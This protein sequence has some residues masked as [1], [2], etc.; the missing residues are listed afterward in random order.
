MA[1]SGL[2]SVEENTGPVVQNDSQP[3]GGSQGCNTQQD[4][5]GISQASPVTPPDQPN[6][7]CPQGSLQR[8]FQM[9]QY[10]Q[11]SCY[12]CAHQPDGTFFLEHAQGTINSQKTK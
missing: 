5:H 3:P 6:Q 9:A 12:Q 7:G 1:V 11:C 2:A 8:P 4:Q 10:N